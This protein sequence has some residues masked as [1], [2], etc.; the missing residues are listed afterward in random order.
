MTRLRGAY[1]AL[2][3]TWPVSSP[4]DHVDRR[5]ADGRPARLSSRAGTG[6]DGALP[7]GAAQGASRCEHNAAGISRSAWTSMQSG[8][9]ADQQRSKDLQTQ[10]QIR[11]DADC[12]GSE[13]HRGREVATRQA[14]I[15]IRSEQRI[16]WF[17]SA[18]L[19]IRLSSP[20]EIV[21]LSLVVIRPNSTRT[22]LRRLSDV[23]SLPS[24]RQS[25][26]AVFV[27]MPHPGHGVL[28]SCFVA[29]LRHQVEKVIRADKNVEPAR[30]ASS[31]CGKFPSA[32]FVEDTQTGAFLAGNS[33]IS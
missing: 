21:R 23:P 7:R 31:K 4:P 17:V 12:A 5:D 16:R 28:Q 27:V 19:P 13:N 8:C 9:S 11:L 1:D 26:L 10:K 32:S 29:S 6:R 33:I 14:K 25:S 2:Q 30:V 18:F 15:G 20:V 24:D 22:V 3:Q